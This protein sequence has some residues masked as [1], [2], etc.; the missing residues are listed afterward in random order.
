MLKK[1]IAIIILFTILSLSLIPFISASYND[2]YI[3]AGNG[4]VVYPTYIL[5]QTCKPFIPCGVERIDISK[6]YNHDYENNNKIRDG[7]RLIDEL[8]S[9]GFSQVIKDQKSPTYDPLYYQNRYQQN[10]RTQY[11]QEQ[12]P[13]VYVDNKKHFANT[14]NTRNNYDEYGNWIYKNED[15]QPN[16][17]T[18]IIYM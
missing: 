1:T 2:D 11:Y 15:Y 10:Y 13:V 9:P 12:E 5:K 4:I 7:D 8:G 16:S 6:D 14:D 18:V 17:K 3:Y